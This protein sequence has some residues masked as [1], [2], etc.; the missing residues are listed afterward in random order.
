LMLCTAFVRS[1]GMPG[2]VLHYFA[3]LHCPHPAV[4]ASHRP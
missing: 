3:P 1:S 4:A 2:L